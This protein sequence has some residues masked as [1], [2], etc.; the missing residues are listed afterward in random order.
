MFETRKQKSE[1][2]YFGKVN[3][4]QEKI[5]KFDKEI[6]EI[7]DIS[8]GGGASAKLMADVFF[9]EAL[10][11]AKNIE[12]WLNS[13]NNG[14]AQNIAMIALM[15]TADRLNETKSDSYKVM[16]NQT[17]ATIIRLKIADEEQ[18]GEM[19]FGGVLGGILDG[20]K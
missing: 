14:M 12:V 2:E 10:E 15:M 5:S 20:R 19:L 18:L 7:K 3:V 16:I 4:S 17:V 1:S 13:Q 8:G 11:T 9:D 6:D